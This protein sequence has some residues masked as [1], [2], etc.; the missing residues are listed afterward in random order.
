MKFK[1]NSTNQK[2]PDIAFPYQPPSDELRKQYAHLFELQS[3]PKIRFLKEIFDRLAALILFVASLPILF[4]LKIAYVIEGL[5]IPENSGNMF[6][7]YNAVSR[8]KTIKKYKIRLIKTKYIDERYAK[9]NDWR[10][11]TSEWNEESRTYVGSFVKKFYLDE[12]PQFFSILK[13]DMSIVGPRPLAELHYQRDLEQGNIVRK[14]LKGGLLGLGHLNK[15]TAEMGNPKYE[16]EYLDNYIEYSP[17]K[18]LKK[19]LWVMWKGFM[20]VLKGGGF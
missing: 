3:P 5:I 15:G 7:Y 20:L 10:A 6:F 17:I 2:E 8:G 13:G 1:E 14:Y 18:L 19:D 4:L 9:L 11:Y 12:L 16:Y